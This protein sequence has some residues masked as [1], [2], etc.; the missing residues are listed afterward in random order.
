MPGI[1]MPRA[2]ELEV[3]C[4][5]LQLGEKGAGH[6]GGHPPESSVGRFPRPSHGLCPGCVHGHVFLTES[7]TVFSYDVM[8]PFQKSLD[9]YG[10]Y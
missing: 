9:V 3:L 4:V 5:P 6:S 10:A 7:H 1:C 2:S 8:N